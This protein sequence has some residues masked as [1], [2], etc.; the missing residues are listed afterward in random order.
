MGG[1]SAPAYFELGGGFF[2]RVLSH[3]EMKKQVNSRVYLAGQKELTKRPKSWP[4]HYTLAPEDV[5]EGLPLSPVQRQGLTAPLGRTR[6][7]V[8]PL[9]PEPFRF[10]WKAPL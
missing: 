1:R 3:L 9:S 4:S 6:R 2:F 10:F 5:G 7:Q 8:R